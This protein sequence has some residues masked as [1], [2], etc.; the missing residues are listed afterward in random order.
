MRKKGKTH[1]GKRTGKI[2]IG[3]EQERKVCRIQETLIIVVDGV[4]IWSY[5]LVNQ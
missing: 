5:G 2:L 1:K 3:I 4:R